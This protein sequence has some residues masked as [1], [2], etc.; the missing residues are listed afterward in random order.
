MLKN[1]RHVPAITKSLISTG[2]LDDVGYV[3]TFGQNMWKI[4][5]G[6]MTVAHGLKSGGLYMIYVSNVSK[7]V[8]NVTEQPNVSLWHRRLGHMSKKEWK[9]C[10]VLVICLAFHF[11]ILNFVSIVCMVSKH[12]S[13]ISIEA[14]GET[15]SWHLFTTICVDLCLTYL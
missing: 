2:L 13:H 9:S 12:S 5:K 1:V 7:N 3:T 10:L 4:S 6:S 11:M 14:A 8:I 15:Q